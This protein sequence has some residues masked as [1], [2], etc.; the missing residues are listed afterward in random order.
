MAFSSTAPR[1]PA[2]KAELAEV[3]DWCFAAKI[4]ASDA[5]ACAKALLEAGYTSR[6]HIRTL[7][8][9][10]AKALT[11]KKVHAKVVRGLKQMPTL[12]ASPPAKKA[13]AS[14][15]LGPAPP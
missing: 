15:N 11:P 5:F 8:P 3:L 9:E 7:T 14:P 2:S 1:A 10:Q 12:E 6:D 13:R 4:E